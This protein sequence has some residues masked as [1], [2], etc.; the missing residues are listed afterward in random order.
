MHAEQVGVWG[1]PPRA[2][3]Q[4][5]AQVRTANKP[6]TG[7]ALRLSNR[8]ERHDMQWEAAARA[9]MKEASLSSRSASSLRKRAVLAVSLRLCTKMSTWCFPALSSTCASRGQMGTTLKR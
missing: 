1:S 2:T 9:R 6:S 8:H 7:P 4:Q 3:V 5:G